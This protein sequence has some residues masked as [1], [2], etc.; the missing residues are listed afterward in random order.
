[1]ESNVYAIRGAT[2][3]NSDNKD[4]IIKEVGSLLSAIYKENEITESEV[5]FTLFSMTDDLHSF[6]AAAAARKSGFSSFSPLFCVQ[7]AK[8]DFSLPRCIRV[9]IL[10]N[11]APLKEAKMIYLNEA[12][13]LR[14]DYKKA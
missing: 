2:T 13:K 7:E 10:V 6:N 11:H 1:M 12:E 5:A 4:E 8:I 14:P 9:M 3:V